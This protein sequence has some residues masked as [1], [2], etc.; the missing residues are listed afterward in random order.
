MLTFFVFDKREGTFQ[1]V[2]RR[3]KR[4]DGTPML[5]PQ[6]WVDFWN[7]NLQYTDGSPLRFVLLEG[8]SY[9]PELDLPLV[10]A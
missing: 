10:K 6:A 8:D 7:A 5:T 1:K 9:T 4:S 3:E 2:E